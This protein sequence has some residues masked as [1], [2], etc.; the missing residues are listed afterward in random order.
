[1]SLPFPI[2]LPSKPLVFRK[3][4]ESCIFFKIQFYTKGYMSLTTGT[5]LNGKTYD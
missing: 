1:M 4:F 2:L 3:V 5:L